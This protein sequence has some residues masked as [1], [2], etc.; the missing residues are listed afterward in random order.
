M[1]RTKLGL[2]GLCAVV[3]GMMAISA[4]AAQGA[5]SWL[6]LNATGTV[7][8]Q[9]TENEK[10]EVNLLAE[11]LGEKD[12]P[13]IALLSSPGGL[14]FS[15]V[16]NNFELIE[17]ELRGGGAL[18]HGKVKFTGCEARSGTF[19]SLANILTETTKLPCTINTA[20][21]ANGTIVTEK[22]EGRLILHTLSGGGTEVLTLLAPLAPSTKF[23]TFL[24]GGT[25]CSLPEED[26][27]TGVLV[28][29]DCEKKAT[30]HA[31]KHLLEEGP[32][33]SIKLGGVASTL[34]GSGW[35]KL[36]NAE[37]GNAWAAMDV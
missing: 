4:S 7:N 29:K 34:L 10:G 28:F 25:E 12:T 14:M 5:L 8:T 21:Q 22:V 32:L 18:S 36:K 17:I 1:T 6:V 9:I 33:S 11:L 20:G 37:A 27:I 19:T 13:H 26:P 23:V 30:V 16:C 31:V 15:I 3:I 2:M 24:F 35:I